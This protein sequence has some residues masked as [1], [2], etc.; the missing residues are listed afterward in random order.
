M[1]FFYNL[2]IRGINFCTQYIAERGKD[3]FDGLT[4]YGDYLSLL[5]YQR[6]RVNFYDVVKMYV[7]FLQFNENAKFSIP[8]VCRTINC[9]SIK[10]LTN[11]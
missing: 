10:I 1:I 8:L 2:N 3:H 6:G 4:V 11:T 5:F 9:S 7:H